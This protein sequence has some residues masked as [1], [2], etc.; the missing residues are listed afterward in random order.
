[1]ELLKACQEPIRASL[2]GARI[3]KQ[4]EFYL[5]LDIMELEQ[6]RDKYETF[7]ESLL[8]AAE[9]PGRA[10]MSSK[11]LVFRF[12]SGST[13]TM[14]ATV[15]VMPCTACEIV[16]GLASDGCVMRRLCLGSN[17]IGDEGCAALARSSASRQPGSRLMSLSEQTSSFP[18]CFSANSAQWLTLRT[19]R[20]TA[21]PQT[22]RVLAF[23]D[24][25]ISQIADLSEE[26]AQ[27]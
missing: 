17:P 20:P 8:D 12:R 7:A 24:V 19:N 14:R 21:H 10:F 27:L 23:S 26:P 18:G 11:G 9:M 13:G 1:M 15:V 16:D 2:I 25:R 5:P 4:M 22:R 3:C 6:A